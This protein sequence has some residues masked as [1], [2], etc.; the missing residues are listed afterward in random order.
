MITGFDH[1]AIQVRDFAATVRNLEIIFG[2]TPNW[3]GLLPPDGE[4]AWFQF[5]NIAL[6]VDARRCGLFR[7]P[8]HRQ[9]RAAQ[10][11]DKPRAGA[12]S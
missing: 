11:D 6:D 5:G 3:R 4:H 2:V 12:R 7:Q 8:G 9:D 1:I 10:H